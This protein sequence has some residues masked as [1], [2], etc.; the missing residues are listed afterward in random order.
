MSMRYFSFTPVGTFYAELLDDSTN[1]DFESDEPFADG[2]AP[3]KSITAANDVFIPSSVHY[4]IIDE[5]Y[6]M[7]NPTNA[8]T[9][10]LYLLEDDTAAALTEQS[11]L[12]YESGAGKA[13]SVLYREHAGSSAKVPAYAHLTDISTI[14]FKLDWT[15][16]PGNTTGLIRIRGRTAQP[17]G[18]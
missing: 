13:D 11:N 6:Y 16:A 15:G 9:Y 1:D 14:Y 18:Y 10:Q 17:L 2:N 12:I 3:T 4:C 8:V 7:M 5:I